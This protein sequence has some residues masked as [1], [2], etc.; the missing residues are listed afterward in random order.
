MDVTKLITTAATLAT[1]FFVLICFTT[2]DAAPTR[3]SRGV[4]GMHMSAG[5]LRDYMMYSADRNHDGKLSGSEIAW[6]YKNEAFYDDYVSAEYGRAFIESADYDQDGAL[7]GDELL[8]MLVELDAY[9]FTK[10][11]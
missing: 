1:I 10:K 2:T 9:P 4:G 7:N 5:I 6:F 11:R 3:R 8:R